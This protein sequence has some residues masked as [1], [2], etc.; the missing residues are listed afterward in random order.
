[1]DEERAGERQHEP[2]ELT[3]QLLE[4][5][6]PPM[7]F[8][9]FFSPGTFSPGS[10]ERIQREAASRDPDVCLIQMFAVGFQKTLHYLISN[11]HYTTW[12]PTHYTFLL[13]TSPSPRDFG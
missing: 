12:F 11:G 2:V 8:F 9:L 10:Q 7:F 4:N 6:F 13:Y 5:Y 3:L 1:M